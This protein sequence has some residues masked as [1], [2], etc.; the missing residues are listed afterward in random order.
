MTGRTVSI[1]AAADDPPPARRRLHRARPELHM[2]CI[3]G[4]LLVRV[5]R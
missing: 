4:R 1:K 2:E 3:H 5:P